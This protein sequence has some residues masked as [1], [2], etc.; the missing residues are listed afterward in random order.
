M[1]GQGV[2][3]G[4]WAEYENGVREKGAALGEVSEEIARLFS[5]ALGPGMGE[6]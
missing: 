4:P 2:M 5:P 1:D 6:H 3:D